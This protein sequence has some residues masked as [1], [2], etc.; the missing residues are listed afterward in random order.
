MIT[1]FGADLHLFVNPLRTVLYISIRKKMEFD[2]CEQIAI[3]SS[4][5]A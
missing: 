2:T 3:T 1:V 4:S 5:L